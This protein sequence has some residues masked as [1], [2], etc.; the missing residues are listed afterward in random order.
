M[1]DRERTALSETACRP[2]LHIIRMISRFGGSG[3]P[4]DLTARF[5]LTA[6]GWRLLPR[7]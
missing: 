5:K 3:K 7:P 1:I 6:A 4:E 2:R